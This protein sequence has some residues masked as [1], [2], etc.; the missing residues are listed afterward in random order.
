MIDKF[1]QLLTEAAEIALND[2]KNIWA[3]FIFTILTVIDTDKE[4][5]FKNVCEDFL[6]KIQ[7]D[8]DDED[9]L[10]NYESI[11]DTKGFIFFIDKEGHS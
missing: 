10:E 9:I 2:G 6:R 1:K 5:A 7:K 8:T 11:K 3:A 4:H